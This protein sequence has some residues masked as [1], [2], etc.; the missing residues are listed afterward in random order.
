MV[1][2]RVPSKLEERLTR[3][4]FAKVEGKEPFN[5]TKAML[6]RYE[7]WKAARVVELKL[8][9]DKEALQ[10]KWLARIAAIPVALFFC[11]YVWMIAYGL[12][13][14]QIDDISKSSHDLVSIDQTPVKFWITVIYHLGIAAIPGLSVTGAGK[15]QDGLRKERTVRRTRKKRAQ[16]PTAQ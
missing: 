14:G 3:E 6:Q 15:E 11:F 16:L 10:T 7:Q 1:R 5:E 8:Q 13:Q 12:V 9:R 4:I 2:K